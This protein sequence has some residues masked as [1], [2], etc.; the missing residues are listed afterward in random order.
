MRKT[1]LTTTTALSIMMLGTTGMC[2][3][4]DSGFGDI[5]GAVL[6]Y[7]DIQRLNDMG[8]LSGYGDGNFYPDSKISVA[9]GITIAEKSFGGEDTLPAKWEDWFAEGCGWED[10]IRVDRYLFRGDYSKNMSYETAAEV[11][12]KL[13]D[14]KVIDATLW[15]KHTTSYNA[16]LNTEQ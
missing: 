11:V 16:Y 2:Y 5:T 13:N 1:I 7:E 15:G 12:L 3:A 9:E 10:N 8:V 4:K 14:L 6:Y